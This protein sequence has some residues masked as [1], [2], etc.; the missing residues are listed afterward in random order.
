MRSERVKYWVGY[1]AV[2]YR[3]VLDTNNILSEVESPW[4][5][6]WAFL[7]HEMCVSTKLSPGKQLSVANLEAACMGRRVEWKKATAKH[8]EQKTD[9][10]IRTRGRE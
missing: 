9:Y 6:M 5:K 7:L 8:V 10:S 2:Q 4:Q 3:I 1:P